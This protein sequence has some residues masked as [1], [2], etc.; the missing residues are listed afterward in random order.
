MQISMAVIRVKYIL[1]NNNSKITS[2]YYVTAS[3]WSH[4][5]SACLFPFQKS[6]CLRALAA[7]GHWFFSLF[8]FFILVHKQSSLK[9]CDINPTFFKENLRKEWANLEGG[10]WPA[11][12]VGWELDDNEWRSLSPLLAMRSM[13][14]RCVWGREGARKE[15]A[16]QRGGSGE[17]R[18]PWS[19]SQNGP[20][21]RGKSKVCVNYFMKSFKILTIWVS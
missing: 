21:A 16:M 17:G 10:R 15:T 2:Y 19:S 6:A 7:N 18:P 3:L 5:A 1:I 11:R 8:F 4:W 12:A 14:S 13:S 20:T 9:S